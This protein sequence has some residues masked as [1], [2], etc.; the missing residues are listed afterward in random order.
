MK[1]YLVFGGDVYYPIGGAYDLK[2]N[3]DTIPEAKRK[4]N[5]FIN[6]KKKIYPPDDVFD[7]VW[8]NIYDQEEM[9]FIDETK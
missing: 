8:A 6:D 7:F 9:I 3:F 1:R 2:G 5:D 4:F